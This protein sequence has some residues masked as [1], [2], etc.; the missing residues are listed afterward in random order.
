M[1]WEH[2]KASDIVHPDGFADAHGFVVQVEGQVR[3]LGE[4]SSLSEAAGRA[5][6]LQA[7]LNS[8]R[9]GH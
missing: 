3:R 7:K 6:H 4:A 9:L 1:E 5:G 8:L 2:C